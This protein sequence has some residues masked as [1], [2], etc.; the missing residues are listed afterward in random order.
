MPSIEEL[1]EGLIEVLHDPLQRENLVHAFQDAV[2]L[3]ETESDD[4]GPGW[5][6]LTDLATHFE[7]YQPDPVMRRQERSLYG[8]DHLKEL[9]LAALKE[10]VQAGA[11]SPSVLNRAED[12]S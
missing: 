7:F 10:L 5:D 12:S 8:D 11:V 4:E 6:T 2:L 3:D 9:I 1:V